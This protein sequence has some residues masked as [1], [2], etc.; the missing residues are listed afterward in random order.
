MDKDYT[1]R[2]LKSASINVVEGMCLKK[3]NDKYIYI[4]NEFNHIYLSFK[5]LSNKIDKTIGYPLFVKPANSGSSIGVHKLANNKKLLEY[6]ED[7]FRYDEKILIEKEIVGRELECAVLGYYNLI[8][9]NP[10]EILKKDYYSYDDK[11]INNTHTVTNIELS[12]KIKEE[13]K[14]I[15]KKAYLACS[16]KGLA[17]V[18]FFLENGTGKI[19]V[20]EINTMPGFTEISM[21]P[22][23]INSVGINNKELINYLIT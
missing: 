14:N 17:R 21:Y 2:I 4:D 19:Y 11:Y 22:K 3:Y 23:L 1:K 15:A 6:I 9:S 13:I 10:G 16:C 12:K 5:E 18:D 20:N 7:A 8:I